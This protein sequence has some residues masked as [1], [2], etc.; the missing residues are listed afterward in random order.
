MNKFYKEVFNPTNGYRRGEI[1]D[2]TFFRHIKSDAYG[3]LTIEV[4]VI[5]MIENDSEY[6]DW[7]RLFENRFVVYVLK[8]ELFHKFKDN[9]F[10]DTDFHIKNGIAYTYPI[11]LEQQKQLKTMYGGK[12]DDK[13]LQYVYYPVKNRLEKEKKEQEIKDQETKQ[14]ELFK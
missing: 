4:I 8:N 10:Q 14:L 7:G 9:G 5:D 3:G 1:I 13:R 2:N 6:L 12:E 11:S